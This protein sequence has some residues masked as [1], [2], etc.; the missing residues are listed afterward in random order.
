MEAEGEDLAEFGGRRIRWKEGG[1]RLEFP[2]PPGTGLLG[3]SG[4]AQEGDL[5]EGTFGATRGGR[6]SAMSTASE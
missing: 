5:G 6:E 2:V 1:D 3:L 4:T